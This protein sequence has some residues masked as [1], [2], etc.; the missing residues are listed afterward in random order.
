MTMTAMASLTP[1]APRSNGR[2]GRPRLPSVALLLPLT[3]VLVGVGACEPTDG[4][5][6]QV[7]APQPAEPF[8]VALGS[9]RE[10]A[11]SAL[12]C[13]KALRAA[14]LND[15]SPAMNYYREQ[16]ADMAAR[17][18]IV[19]SYERIVRR[20]PSDPEMIVA[21]YVQGWE[22]VVAYYVDGLAL[23]RAEVIGEPAAGTTVH[24]HV[25]A[26]APRGPA[27]IRVECVRNAGG[28]WLVTRID[29]APPAPASEPATAPVP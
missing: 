28:H 1:A 17:E 2:R 4:T 15:D 7:T 12:S 5:G 9:P 18:V 13:L 8:S 16:L 3:V 6:R 24:V 23:D 10:T 20:R 19:R 11:L 21:R 26:D 14:H 29:F 22:A 25:P 27:V